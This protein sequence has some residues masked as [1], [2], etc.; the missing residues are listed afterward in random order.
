MMIW[1]IIIILLLLIL[2]SAVLYITFNGKYH[3]MTLASAPSLVN[4]GAKFKIDIRIANQCKHD[5]IF[6][7]LSLDKKFLDQFIFVGISPMAKGQ[8]S[9]LGG[10]CISYQKQLSPNESMRIE[11]YFEAIK[12]G[13]FIGN[14]SAINSKLLTGKAAKVKITVE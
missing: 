2:L 12:P 3:L 14:F 7:M 1:T 6:D 10:T 9:A 4:V 5:Q 13:I 11:L 8:A